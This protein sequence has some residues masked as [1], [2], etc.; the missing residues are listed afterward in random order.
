MLALR[1]IHS[2][3]MVHYVLCRHI[4]HFQEQVT[5]DIPSLRV[6]FLA[7][8]DITHGT[9]VPIVYGLHSMV[10]HGCHEA[11]LNLIGFPLICEDSVGGC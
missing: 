4:L 8:S 1:T 9:I 10:Q 2:L 11:F 5:F 7:D 6:F 3:Q